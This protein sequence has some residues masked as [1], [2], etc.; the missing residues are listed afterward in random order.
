M[1]VIRERLYAHPV[2]YDRAD[3]PMARGIYCYPSFVLFIL[4]DQCL[5]C[6]EYVY[7]CTI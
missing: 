1:F 2:V 3:E 5:N 4:P 6:E 7:L